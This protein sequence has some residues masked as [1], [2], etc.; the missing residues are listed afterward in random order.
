[1]KKHN[2]LLLEK[3][4]TGNDVPEDNDDDDDDLPY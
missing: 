1:M 2:S 4:S 3:A